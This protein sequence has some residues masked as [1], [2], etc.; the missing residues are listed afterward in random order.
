MVRG[1]FE[2]QNSHLKKLNLEQYNKKE[3]AKEERFSKFTSHIE[4]DQITGRHQTVTKDVKEYAFVK[5]IR[6]QAMIFIHG[7][8]EDLELIS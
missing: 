8:N 1:K 2:S 6:E 7:I 3:M 4:I 5:E